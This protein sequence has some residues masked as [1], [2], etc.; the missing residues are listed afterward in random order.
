MKIDINSKI[1]LFKA[2]SEKNS[3]YKPLVKLTTGSSD[4]Q[5]NLSKAIRN[6]KDA[7]N[8][9]SDLKSAFNKTKT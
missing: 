1:E 3:Q 5:D 4:T 7:E 9:I 6:K 2:I 8:F